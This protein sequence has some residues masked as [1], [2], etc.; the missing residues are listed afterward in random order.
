MVSIRVF[1]LSIGALAL[2]FVL[3]GCSG[4][5]LDMFSGPGDSTSSARAGGDADGLIGAP[6]A[7]VLTGDELREARGAQL[8]ALDQA[9]A[10]APSSWQ[11]AQGTAMGTIVVGPVY[12]AKGKACRS[13]THTVYRGSKPIVSRGSACRQPEGAWVS[14]S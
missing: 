1:L 5:R 8:R 13:Y 2:A 6:L 10:G 4:Q 3:S 9:P 12:D 14:V 7:R 11:S